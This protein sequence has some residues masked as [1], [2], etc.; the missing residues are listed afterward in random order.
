MRR[1]AETAASGIRR[2][3]QISSPGV[4]EHRLAATFGEDLKS[5]QVQEKLPL[6]V[7]NAKLDRQ[8][9]QWLLQWQTLRYQV[10]GENWP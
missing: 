5:S 3:M 6:P 7:S 1:S 9:N 4:S 8:D 10:S 2:C